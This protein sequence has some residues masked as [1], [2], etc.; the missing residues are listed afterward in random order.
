M[1]APAPRRA[2]RVLF[3]SAYGAACT[4]LVITYSGRYIPIL[5]YR[6]V[7]S[8]YE[9]EYTA[10]PRRVAVPIKFDAYCVRYRALRCMKM[11]SHFVLPYDK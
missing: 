11:F 8:E 1:V 10:A 3:V 6:Y 5:A 4:R 9:Y 2:G 7:S